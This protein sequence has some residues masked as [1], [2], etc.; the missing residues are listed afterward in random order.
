MLKTA[1]V[2]KGISGSGKSTRTLYLINTLREIFTE[3]SICYNDKQ[4]G[5]LFEEIGV[6][7]LGKEQKKG[8]PFQGYDSC[9]GVFEK[10]ENLSHFMKESEYSFVVEGSGIT[11]SNR[12]RPKFLHE[13]CGFDVTLIQYYNFNASQK[14]F[15]QKRILDRSGKLPNKDSMFN[16]IKNFEGDY[17]R[18]IK[19]A[20]ESDLVFY[21]DPSTP[22]ND[23]ALKFFDL[24]EL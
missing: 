8:L 9:T 6:V 11:D 1:F 18:S 15:Y 24:I 7:F 4:V 5:L 22:I 13:Y 14:E 12:L 23:F 10:A 20:S 3:K 21:D 16:K 2:V 17:E 19:E